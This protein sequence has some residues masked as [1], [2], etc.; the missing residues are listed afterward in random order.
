I[1][2]PSAALGIAEWVTLHEAVNLEPG[3]QRQERAAYLPR[4][5]EASGG[6]QVDRKEAKVRRPSRILLPRLESPADAFLV[7]ASDVERQ[8]E[9]GVREEDVNVEWRQP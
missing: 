5:F 3:L 7:L 8:P 9:N 1:G 2:E 4:F 6:G